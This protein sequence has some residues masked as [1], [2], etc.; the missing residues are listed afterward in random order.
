MIFEAYEASQAMIMVQIVDHPAKSGFKRGQ[1][2]ARKR[3][4]ERDLACF[5]ADDVAALMEGYEK[6]VPSLIRPLSRPI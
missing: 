1:R 5:E 6:Q 2:Q 4:L 3:D